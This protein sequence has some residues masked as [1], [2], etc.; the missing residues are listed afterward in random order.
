MFSGQG[1]AVSHRYHKYIGKSGNTWLVADTETAAENVYVTDSPRNDGK[2]GFGGAALPMPCVD[3]TTFVLKGGWHSN[4][5]A[6]FEDTGVDVRDKYRTLVVLALERDSTED[7]TFRT[8]FR[9]IVYR[10][11]APVLGSYH[12]DKLL[13]AQYPEANYCYHASKGGSSSCM[14][15]EG[16][17]RWKAAGRP[18]NFPS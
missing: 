5:D 10:D 16:H 11:A 6:L 2:Q 4:A 8:I 12:R 13:M 9:Q 7:G 1:E 15:D 17:K 14:T 18:R 3:G